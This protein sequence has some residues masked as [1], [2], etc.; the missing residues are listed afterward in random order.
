MAEGKIELSVD[1]TLPIGNKVGDVLKKQGTMRM[2]TA[3]DEIAPW[4]DPRVKGNPEY[5]MV[6]IL[7][8]VVTRLE[9]V[10]RINTDTIENLYVKDYEFLLGLYNRLNENGFDAV[11][12]VCDCGKRFFVEVPKPGELSATP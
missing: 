3:A 4:Q 5:I 8:R 1:F 9:G 10:E 12:A 11:E 6:I 7:A 2:A